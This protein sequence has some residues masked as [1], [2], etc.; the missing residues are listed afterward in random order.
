MVKLEEVGIDSADTLDQQSNGEANAETNAGDA[1]DVDFAETND[2]DI[3]DESDDS[4]D[5]KFEE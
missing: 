3:F 1:G 5:D 4:S 2:D